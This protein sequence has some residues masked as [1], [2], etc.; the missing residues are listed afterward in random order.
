MSETILSVFSVYGAPALFLIVAAGQF[1]IPLP[2][3]ILLLTAGALQA[4]GELTFLQLFGWGLAG[5]LAGDH[6]GYAAGRLAAGAI[7][8]R[9]SRW[10]A[11]QKNMD[12]AEAFTRRWGDRSV[13]LSRWLFS[14]LGP[15]VNVSSGLSSHPLHRF[16]LADIAGEVVWIGGYLMLGSLFA[17]SIAEL[18][19]VVANA[20]WMTGAALITLMLGWQL[21]VRIRRI[22]ASKN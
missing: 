6:A 10:P 16:T 18:A 7:R 20:A 13:F 1:G 21:L 2:T 9:V 17:Q 4:D 14:P 12:R 11:V 5:A 3:S 15:W 19:D 22:R 8:Q